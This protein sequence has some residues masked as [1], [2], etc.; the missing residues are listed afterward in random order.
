ML[1]ICIG[2]TIYINLP[3]NYVPVKKQGKRS[4]RKHLSKEASRKIYI[5]RKGEKRKI[6]KFS[7]DTKLFRNWR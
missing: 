2:P 6:L 4:K 5:R 3:I 7:D 1:L